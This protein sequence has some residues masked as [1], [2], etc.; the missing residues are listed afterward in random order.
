MSSLDIYVNLKP[1]AIKI[2]KLWVF[3]IVIF[4]LGFLY[5]DFNQ[6]LRQE[7]TAPTK[8]PTFPFIICQP[9]PPARGVVVQLVVALTA[10]YQ[11]SAWKLAFLM[12]IINASL[13][14]GFVTRQPG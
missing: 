5:P 3:L 4:L 7:E 14:G 11:K 8:P 9:W 10:E 6:F 2:L 12:C 13:R 1:E